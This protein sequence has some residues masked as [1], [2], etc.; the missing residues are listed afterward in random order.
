[1]K[2]IDRVGPVELSSARYFLDTKGLVIDRLKILPGL[3]HENRPILVRS[4]DN[5]GSCLT[6]PS[7]FTTKSCR[8]VEPLK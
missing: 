5:V 8:T 3:L 2:Y 1:M 6:G 4:N 7:R